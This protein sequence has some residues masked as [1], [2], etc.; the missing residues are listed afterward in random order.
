MNLC[1]LVVRNAAPALA[2]EPIVSW[3]GSRITAGEKVGC[4]KAANLGGTTGF[5]PVPF[6]GRDYFFNRP[7]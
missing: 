5:L 2:G 7:R 4:W 6:L 3:N 1:I